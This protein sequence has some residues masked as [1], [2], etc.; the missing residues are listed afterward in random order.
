MVDQ[1][2][3]IRV[4]AAVIERNGRLLLGQRP[5]GHRH[6]GLW[7]FPGGKVEPGEDDL[8]ATRRELREELHVTVT[9]VGALLAEHRDPGT[10]FVIAFRRVEIAGEP[11]CLDHAELGWFAPDALPADALAPSDL[12]FCRDMG[13][14]VEG[15]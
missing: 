5:S 4:V 7:E 12:R 2:I 1:P 15:K 13:W 11:R 14:P 3:A 10:A 9:A 8:D 6:G